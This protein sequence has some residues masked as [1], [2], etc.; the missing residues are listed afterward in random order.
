MKNELGAVLNNGILSEPGDKLTANITKTGRQVVK[1]EKS[2]GQKAS[3]TK[4]KT[5][6]TVYTFSS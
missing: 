4:Y 3:A 1:V 6:K 2:N 5:G